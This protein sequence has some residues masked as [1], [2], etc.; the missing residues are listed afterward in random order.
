MD[1]PLIQ[2]QPKLFRK[3]EQI[4][5]WSVFLPIQM[6]K[7]VLSNSLKIFCQI[8]IIMQSLESKINILEKFI[9]EI[10]SMNTILVENE[11]NEE[12]FQTKLTEIIN[13]FETLDSDSD[14]DYDSDTDSDISFTEEERELIESEEHCAFLKR[15]SLK[16]TVEMPFVPAK[17]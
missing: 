17:N 5:K 6:C 7:K 15:Y 2:I 13:Q 16:P 14:S 4:K 1:I 3:R 8:T 9:S 10:Q 12:Q 11:Q